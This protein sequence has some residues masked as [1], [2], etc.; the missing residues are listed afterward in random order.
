MRRGLRRWGIRRDER[1][2][3]AVEFAFVAPIFL[4]FVLGI[5]DLSAY[6]FVAA[7]LQT[8]VEQAARS[9]RVG[10]VTLIGPDNPPPA[11][12]KKDVFRDLVCGEIHTFMI[13]NCTSSLL[14]DVQSFSSDF[15]DVSY[16][17][18]SD[19]NG[20]GVIDGADTAYS[21]GSG[22]SAI[23]ARVYYRYSFIVPQMALLTGATAGSH[24]L[25][26]IT[27]TT[28]FRNEPFN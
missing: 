3:A 18:I 11:E 23:I 14:V 10:D 28:A 24:N 22:G 15:S 12:P 7:Q 17:D 4:V 26:A 20:D 6:F 8:A 27:A 13:R 1:G 9:I 25:I 2:I 21:A 5:M 19:A 16:G